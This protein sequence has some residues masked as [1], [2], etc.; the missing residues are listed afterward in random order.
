MRSE[1]AVHTTARG[2]A[3]EQRAVLHMVAAGYRVCGTN[4]RIGMSELD[5]VAYDGD[6][7]CFVE[8]RARRVL[9]DALLSVSKSKQ[10]HLI[11]AAKR[12]L[13]KH[14]ATQTLPRCR[15]DVVAVSAEQIVVV[16]DA[17]QVG[18]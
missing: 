7:L 9:S 8:V 10:Q 6:I 16:K 13:L 5:V 1:A 4:I 2:R 14:H 11:T 17:F 18:T 12:Y 15:F 3:A